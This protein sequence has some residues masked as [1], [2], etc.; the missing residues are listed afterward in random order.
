MG[1]FENLTFHFKCWCEFRVDMVIGTN[2]TDFDRTIVLTSSSS[3][4]AKELSVERRILDV[5]VKG[6]FALQRVMCVFLE[7]QL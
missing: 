3:T 6:S 1:I 4:S 5:L 7:R 2:H